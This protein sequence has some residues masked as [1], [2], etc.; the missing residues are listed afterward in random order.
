MG[1]LTA[2]IALAGMVASGVLLLA[3]AR[4]RTEISPAGDLVVSF[5]IGA[6]AITLIVL[7]VSS[8]SFWVS[9]ASTVALTAGLVAAAAA[10]PVAAGVLL[11]RLRYAPALL[12]RV[13][14]R[15][16]WL[17]ALPLTALV[18]YQVWLVTVAALHSGPGWDGVFI[19][20]I[21]ARYF[22]T[23]GGIPPSFFSDTSRQWSHPNY[24]LL[25]P[26][27]EALTFRTLGG[28]HQWADMVVTAAFVLGLAVLFHEVVRRARGPLLASLLTLVLITSP[29]FWDNALQAFADLPAALFLLA[30]AW[31]VYRWFDHERR[32]QDMILGGTMLAL[33]MWVKREGLVVWST[34]AVVM[35]GWTVYT[36]IRQ[37]SL[38]WRPLCAYLV[39]AGALLPWWLAVAHGG[40]PDRDFVPLTVTWVL[41]HADRVPVLM[42]M[43]VAQLALVPMW[44]IAWI[45]IG[46]GVVLRPPVRSAGRRFLLAAV[47][48]H[49][50]VLTL[51]YTF[52]SWTPYTDHVNASIMRVMFQVFPVGL[53]LL[54]TGLE[55]EWWRLVPMPR[56]RHTRGEGGLP[57]RV[58]P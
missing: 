19:W 13:R 14:R 29:A 10:L 56:P 1:S 20:E 46:A 2:L 31:F 5:L 39:P 36:S 22:L 28:A 52:S 43:L 45:L 32:L 12:G 4:I 16:A 33:A 27:V 50:I 26:L 48:A 57:T 37:R 51:I 55:R 41:D 11:A 17:L 18:A 3:A 58:T 40:V 30:G 44:G 47:L 24:P 53:L 6:G 25:L 35:A 54:A 9:W 23:F 7:W 49:T 38:R 21:K 34:G 8:L 42:E 15:P